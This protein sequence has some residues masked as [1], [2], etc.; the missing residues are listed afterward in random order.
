[1]YQGR[2]CIAVIVSGGRGARFGG[3]IPKQYLEIGGKPVLAFSLLAFESCEFVD[4]IR[5]VASVGYIELCERMAQEYGISKFSEVRRGGESRQ[6]SVYAGIF[7]VSDDDII[8]IHDSA[9]PF[10]TTEQIRGLI[11]FAATG[12]VISAAPVTDTIKVTAN[13]QTQHTPD[14][15]TL[16]AAQTPQGFLGTIIKKAHITAKN[17]GFIGSDDAS[18]VERIGINCAIL[19]SDAANIK[20]TTKNDFEFARFITEAKQPQNKR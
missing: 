15:S 18:L 11:P 7:D 4:E 14:R 17:D 12:A 16:Y 2:K 20:I 3:D 5:I 10:V 1:M 13:N 9:R 8:L 19:P 6:E